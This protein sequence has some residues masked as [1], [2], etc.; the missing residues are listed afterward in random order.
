[1]EPSWSLEAARTE[2]EVMV[3]LPGALLP[4]L[5]TLQRRFGYVHPE[6]VPLLADLLNLSQAE[7][8]GVIS[9]YRDLR[10]APPAGP[11]VRV[12]RAE[13]CQAVGADGLWVHAQGVAAGLVGGAAVELSD[14]FCLGNCALGPSVQAG[15]RLYGRVD[16]GRFDSLVALLTE[17]GP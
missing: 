3:G 4:M 16:E 5:H 7:V 1:M 6:A 11:A 17:P 2:V 9:F 10:T 15:G 8:H 12:C 14:V 13:A